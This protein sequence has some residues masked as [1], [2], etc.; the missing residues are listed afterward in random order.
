M[1]HS[2]DSWRLYSKVAEKERTLTSRSCTEQSASEPELPQQLLRS[3]SAAALAA[4]CL[5][6]PQVSSSQAQ[7][8]SLSTIWFSDCPDCK[9]AGAFA[10]FCEHF[11]DYIFAGGMQNLEAF[12]NEMLLSFR[13]FSCG[14]VSRCSEENLVQTFCSR[15]VGSFDHHFS[16]TGN[17]Y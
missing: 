15:E 9:D 5:H 7:V 8:T 2:R 17:A 14:S 6:S 3:R 1:T 13:L 11:H 4:R 10:V 16:T 12:V